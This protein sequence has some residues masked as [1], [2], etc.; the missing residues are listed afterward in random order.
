MVTPWVSPADYSV[1]FKSYPTYD[2][3]LI[4]PIRKTT[5]PGFFLDISSTL[6][7][8]NSVIANRGNA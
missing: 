3:Y 6:R 7:K 2:N 8:S 4:N 5:V 1:T